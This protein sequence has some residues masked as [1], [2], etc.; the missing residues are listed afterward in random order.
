MSKT[1]ALPEWAYVDKPLTKG[2]IKASPEDFGVE[3]IL[4]FELSGTGEHLY[5]LLEK[6][7]MNTLDVVKTLS[8]QLKLDPA[9]I[10]YAGLK[11]K[12]A[13]TRQWISLHSPS[14]ISTAD[15]EAQ[16][17]A[18]PGFRVLCAKRHNNK[19]KRGAHQA[20][21]FDIV[22]RNLSA[23]E[24]LDSAIKRVQSH[25]VPNY[26]GEQRFGKQGGNIEKARA[27]FAGK[28]KVERQLRGIYL[29]SA[30][31][32]L[33]NQVLSERVRQ[34]SWAAG[35]P[36]EVFMLDG[37]NSFFKTD[38]LD[39]R[40][41]ERLD[42]FDIHPSAPLW[43]TGDLKTAKESAM[44]ESE[45]VANYPDLTAG[46]EAFGLRQQRRATRLIPGELSFFWQDDSSMK[47]SF[48]LS[49]GNFATTVLRELITMPK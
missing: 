32:F 30:R 19:L 14:K 9:R 1:T 49:K 17:L 34:R 28:G 13:T 33:F 10:S 6:C 37:S 31:S 8:K 47:I 48:I 45:V 3:E 5:L 39:Q 7:G 20:N 43:G 26:F 24:G 12:Q 46:L 16:A 23:T 38:T 2:V 44:L 15:F 41:L 25:G 21:R 18:R 29:S 4:G 27:L 42:A 22:I 40:L 35:L 11:D 36:G